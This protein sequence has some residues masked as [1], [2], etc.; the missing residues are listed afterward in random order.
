MK[1]TLFACMA[2]L[3]LLTGAPG[4]ATDQPAGTSP[5]AKPNK[6]TITNV[7]HASVC[8]TPEGKLKHKKECAETAG[9]TGTTNSSN[10][11]YR[12]Q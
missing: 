8:N 1:K 11:S 9:T 3:T 2:A 6:T 5:A 7:G 10:S 4:F 12:H